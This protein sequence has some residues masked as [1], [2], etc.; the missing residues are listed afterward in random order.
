MKDVFEFDVAIEDILNDRLKYF[1]FKPGYFYMP[2][3]KNIL[4]VLIWTGLLKGFVFLHWFV[5]DI[6]KILT[7]L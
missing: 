5:K 7:S 1:I 4:P 3:G 2:S 6:P